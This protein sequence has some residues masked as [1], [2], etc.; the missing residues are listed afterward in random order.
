MV[1]ISDIIEAES[2][3]FLDGGTRE[4]VI[5]TLVQTAYTRGKIPSGVSFDKDEGWQ[6]FDEA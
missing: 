5:K 1:R 2:V 6:N 3:V 4:N